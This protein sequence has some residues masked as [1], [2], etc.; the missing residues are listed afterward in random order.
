MIGLFKYP[1]AIAMAF[2]V[3]VEPTVI[4]AVY[5]VDAAVGVTPCKA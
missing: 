5:F 3:S 2:M 1:G 4:G